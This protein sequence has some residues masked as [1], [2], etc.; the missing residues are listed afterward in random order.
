MIPCFSLS[1]DKER[2]GVRFEPG[3]D[4]P[5]C[6]D[7]VSGHLSSSEERIILKKTYESSNSRI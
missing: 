6:P 1:L 3:I 4:Q 5:H 7:S 2:V